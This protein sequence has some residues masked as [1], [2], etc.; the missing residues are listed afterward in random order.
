VD[1]RPWKVYVLAG[2]PSGGIKEVIRTLDALEK[3]GCEVSGWILPVTCPTYLA[4]AADRVAAYHMPM[5]RLDDDFDS[6]VAEL[7]EKA[8]SKPVV[9]RTG[10][11]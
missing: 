1:L 9:P 3:L 5:G 7:R 6:T 2:E 10:N 4:D 8:A 11:D